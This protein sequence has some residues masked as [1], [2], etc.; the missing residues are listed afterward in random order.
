[1]P[2]MEDLLRSL[3]GRF[4][5]GLLSDTDSLHWQ[6]LRSHYPI[7]SIFPR[8]VLSFEVGIM[9]P[10]PEIYRLAAES[11]RTCPEH[12]LYIDDLSVN[13]E[14]A[15]QIGME[16]IVFRQTDDLKQNLISRD[17]LPKTSR[18]TCP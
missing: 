16:A 8:P 18:S 12:C 7:L 17:I 4:P 3:H 10:N 11:V 13:V 2:G 9:K 15:R 14:G 6:H 5:L 1:M